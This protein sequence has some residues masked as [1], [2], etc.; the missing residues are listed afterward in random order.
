MY[1]RKLHLRNLK[2]VRELTLDFEHE[3]QPRMW[4]V[5]IGENGTAKTSILQAV[6]MAAA[7][8]RQ[9]NTLARPVARH[10]RDRRGEEAMAVEAIFSFG[11][12]SLASEAALPA[13][14]DQLDLRLRSSVTLKPGS[15]SVEAHSRYEQWGEDVPSTEGELDDAR[16]THRPYWFIAGYGISRNL[17]ESSYTPNLDAP[18]SIACCRC[19]I[20]AL[21]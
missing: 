9:V 17:P 14:H 19:S 5:L 21:L 20:L 13:L 4:T 11:P 2:R 7:G 6:A 15:T 3:G 1:L 18:P 12:R 10:L 16:E 8:S